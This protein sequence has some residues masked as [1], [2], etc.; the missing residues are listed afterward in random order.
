M[1]LSKFSELNDIYNFQETII[2]L[3]NVRKEI[4]RND[5]KISL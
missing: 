5:A 2:F 3:L 1:Q 4:D